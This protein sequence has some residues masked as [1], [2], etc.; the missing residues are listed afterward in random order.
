M[1]FPRLAIRRMVKKEDVEGLVR[2]LVA[3]IRGGSAPDLSCAAARAITHF[4]LK[5]MI[6]DENIAALIVQFLMKKGQVGDVKQIE[7][8]VALL[9]TEDLIPRGSSEE[10]YANTYTWRVSQGLKMLRESI[11]EL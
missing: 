11:R 6:N 10:A 4:K 3:S 7:L 2:V 1:L 9:M 5:G 8:A